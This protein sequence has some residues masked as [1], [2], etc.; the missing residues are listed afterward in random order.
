MKRRT[1]GILLLISFFIMT[2]G[3]QSSMKPKEA[4]DITAINENN[5][6][7]VNGYKVSDS[8][9]GEK[10]IYCTEDNKLILVNNSIKKV[11]YD[12][13]CQQHEENPYSIWSFDEYKI[14]WSSDSKYVYIIDTVYDLENDRFIPLE[15]CVVFSWKGNK[16]IYLADGTYY[17]V[18]LDGGLQNEMSVGKKIKTIEDGVIKEIGNQ[19]DD[20]Y[21]VLDKYNDIPNLFSYIGDYLIINT[22]R[23]KYSED[24]LQKMIDRDM[25]NIPNLTDRY[26]EINAKYEETIANIRESEEFQSLMNEINELEKDYPVEIEGENIVDMVNENDDFGYYN[27]SG[28][29]YLEDL[30][31]EEIEIGN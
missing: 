19:A 28:K 8:Q 7:S 4:S 3:C 22:A 18:S 2:S 13:Y 20:R 27:V 14:Q 6:A 17:E 5:S 26:E 16:G 9:D 23:L 24:T 25:H 12:N 10:S 21:Y 11:I 15:D 29:F 30:I 1:I 31:E